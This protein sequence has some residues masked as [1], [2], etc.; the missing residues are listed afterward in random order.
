MGDIEERRNGWTWESIKQMRL[1]R[2]DYLELYCKS[3]RSTLNSFEAERFDELETILP[4]ET[5][6]L[7]VTIILLNYKFIVIN[8]LH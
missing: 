6:I 5:I 1:Y 8:I 3:N 4:Y 7:Y 2:Q